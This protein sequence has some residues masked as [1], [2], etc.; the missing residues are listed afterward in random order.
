MVILCGPLASYREACVFS[1]VGL[2]KPSEISIPYFY[3]TQQYVS[4]LGKVYNHA[5]F[6]WD[7]LTGLVASQRS[8]EMSRFCDFCFPFSVSSSRLQCQTKALPCLSWQRHWSDAVPRRMWQCHVSV[9]TPRLHGQ[10]KYILTII[11]AV[12]LPRRLW[13]SQCSGAVLR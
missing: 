13:Q 10:I 9:A 2:E 6:G 1:H 8:G 12:A 7:R 5:K 3:Y 11:F 4:R